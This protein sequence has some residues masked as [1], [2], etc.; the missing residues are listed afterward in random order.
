M[1]TVLSVDVAKNKSMIMLMNNDGEILIDTKEIKH[2]LGE[3]EK[4]KEEIKEI[5]EQL[6]YSVN[7]TLIG[8]VPY[9]NNTADDLIFTMPSVYLGAGNQT[10]RFDHPATPKIA[11]FYFKEILIDPSTESNIIDATTLPAEFNGTSISSIT[12]S[13]SGRMI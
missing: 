7:G 8:T 4:V 10:I 9:S 3:F 1:K 11:G 5:N 6:K 2:N 13:T 12:G